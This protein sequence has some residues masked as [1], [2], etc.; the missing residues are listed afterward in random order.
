MKKK[1]MNSLCN[2]LSNTLEDVIGTTCI[3]LT[4][5]IMDVLHADINHLNETDYTLL[6]MRAAALAR[7]AHNIPKISIEEKES[8]DTLI[9]NIRSH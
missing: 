4:E 3:Q 2:K 1:D 5:K 6:Y 9:R 7:I 8:L